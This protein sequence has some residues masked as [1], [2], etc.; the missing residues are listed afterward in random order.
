MTVGTPR[1]RRAPDQFRPGA[2]AGVATPTCCCCCCVGSVV[3]AAV[4]LPQQIGASA[5]RDSPDRDAS[6]GGR[7]R[8]LAGAAVAVPALPAGLVAATLITDEVSLGRNASLELRLA[9]VLGLAG[10]VG[11]LL[12]VLGA[13]LAGVRRDGSYAR[14]VG[15]SLL[16]GVLFAV[17]VAA[18]MVVTTLVGTYANLPPL[19]LWPVQVTVV[20]LAALAL[21]R[22]FRRGLPPPPAPRRPQTGAATPRE[23]R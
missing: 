16:L 12:V 17:E 20:L 6:P 1:A 2:T 5:R 18:F 22:R 9:E 19:L 13:A 4:V 14:L 15:L 21:G 8:G 23:G 11:V 3:G 7:A 10:A